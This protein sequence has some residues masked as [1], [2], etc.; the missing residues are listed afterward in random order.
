MVKIDSR[1]RD[2]GQS[3]F[4]GPLIMVKVD[5]RG[6]DYGQS[7]FT[8]TNPDDHQGEEA[9]RGVRVVGLQDDGQTRIQLMWESQRDSSELEACVASGL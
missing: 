7:R 2:Y 3:R 1:G 8:G 9:L 4:A 6:R 5:L